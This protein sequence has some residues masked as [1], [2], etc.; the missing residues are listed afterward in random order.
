MKVEIKKPT[1]IVYII[2]CCVTIICFLIILIVLYNKKTG[3]NPTVERLQIKLQNLI[4]SGRKDCA[5]E[6]RYC[7][8][9]EDCMYKCIDSNFSC[10]NGI[11]KKDI[12]KIPGSNVCDPSKGVLGFLLGNTA[13]G[14]YEFICKSIDPGIAITVDNN[15]MCHGDK[16]YVIDYISNYPIIK[17]CKCDNQITIPA[18]SVKREHVEC[19]SEFVDFVT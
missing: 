12:N 9:N 10:I 6:R 17:A 8:G 2:L 13:L 16:D 3:K 11:C 19:N 15:R 7:F 4:G 5:T 18:T 1:L 14:T